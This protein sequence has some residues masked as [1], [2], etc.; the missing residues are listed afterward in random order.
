MP[1]AQNDGVRIYYKLQGDGDR[2]PIVLLNSIGTE[3]AMWDRAV[4]YLLDHFLVLRID[5]RGHGASD[6]PPHDYDLPLLCRDVRAV[7][8]AAGIGGAVVAGVSLGGMIA[9]ELALTAPERVNGLALICTTAT[10]HSQMWADRIDKVRTAGME[11]IV[12]AV[13]PRFL[14][15]DFAEYHREYAETIRRAFLSTSPIGY[16][17]CGAAI[18]DMALLDR[19]GEIAAPTLVVIGTRDRATPLTGNG[20][21]ILAGIPSSAMAE[22]PGAHISPIDAPEELAAVLAAHFGKDESS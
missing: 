6:A 7:M 2:P 8:D 5:T 14:D 16:S 22:V 19:L 12:D 11:S 9:M 10:V 13:M 17:G 18:R 15:P 21:F 20:E 4:P 1:F 3:M